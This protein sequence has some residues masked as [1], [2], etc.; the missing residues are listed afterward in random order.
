MHALEMGEDDVSVERVIVR[1]SSMLHYIV[2]DRVLVGAGELLSAS[3]ARLLIVHARRLR[4]ELD[5]LV[6]GRH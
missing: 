6:R 5:R 2:G 4:R 3:W 1:R